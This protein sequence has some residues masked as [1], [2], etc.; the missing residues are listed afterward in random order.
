MFRPL[1]LSIDSCPGPEALGIQRCYL[2]LSGSASHSLSHLL[3]SLCMGHLSCSLES[4]SDGLGVC[5]DL[6]TKQRL[7]V[8]GLVPMVDLIAER[9]WVTGTLT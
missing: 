2:H 5:Y 1:C 4:H 9:S 7:I 3:L 6:E 8:E